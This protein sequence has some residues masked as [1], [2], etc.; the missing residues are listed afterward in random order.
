MPPCDPGDT[1]LLWN[2]I[3]T[4]YLRGGVELEADNIAG[5]D[6]PDHA[7]Q[8][9]AGAAGAVVVDNAHLFGAVVQHQPDDGWRG[10]GSCALVLSSFIHGEQGLISCGYG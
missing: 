4:G 2:D 5:G 1:P 3:T 9:N 8:F 6:F 10:F 7:V